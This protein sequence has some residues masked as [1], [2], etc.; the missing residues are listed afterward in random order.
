VWTREEIRAYVEKS[1]AGL[2]CEVIESVN[3]HED[4][5]MGLPFPGRYIETTKPPSETLPR[6]RED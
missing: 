5:K 6:S 4:I 2:E 3:V 1:R